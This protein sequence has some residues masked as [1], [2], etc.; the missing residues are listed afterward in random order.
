MTHG[1]PADSAE[2]ALAGVLETALYYPLAARE[3]MLAFYGEVLALREVAGWPDG[4]AYR[5]GP[6]VLLLFCRELLAEREGPIAAHGTEGPGHVCLLAGPGAYDAWRRRLEEAGVAI[7]HEEEWSR[8][9]RSF[10]FA[11][12]AGNLLEIAAADIWPE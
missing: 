5:L 6:G 12:P 10:Y 7:T 8:G 11:D 3:R 1:D 9:R 2:P 4:T